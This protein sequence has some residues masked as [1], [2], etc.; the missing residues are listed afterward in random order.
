MQ[1]AVQL[2][3][4]NARVRPSR[5]RAVLH[6]LLW[7]VLGA[8]AVYAIGALP[9]PRSWRL[10][11][12]TALT[13]TSVNVGLAVLIRQQYVVNA[14]FRL[15]TRAPRRWPLRWRLGLAEV[16][17]YGGVHVGAAVAA[18][19]WFLFFATETVVH[20][21]HYS[22]PV[23]V[24]T[25]A[26]AV[27]LIVIV[28]GSSP[29]VRRRHH[30]LFE[31]VHR[32][33]GWAALGLFA[34]LTVLLA[35][36]DPRGL[37]TGLAHTPTAW[38]LAG[39]AVSIVI[40]WLQLRRLAV[41]AYVPSS[42]AAVLH[43]PD[44]RRA[45]AGTFVRLAHQRLGQSH[46]FAAIPDP[47]G[48]GYR[49]IVSRAGDWT[50]KLIDSP[51]DRVWVRGVPID[52]VASVARLFHRVVWLAT[53]SG[54]APC[55]PHLL[56]GDATRSHLVWVTRNPQRTYGQLLDEI[57]AAAPDAQIWDTDAHGKPDLAVLATYAYQRTG[58]EA[59]ICISNQDTTNR[60]VAQLRRRGVPAYGPIWDS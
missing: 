46:A 59:V 21:G 23:R 12:D 4:I 9:S 37:A 50:G 14:L 3:T 30:D 51:P 35:A 32:Y 33:G 28:A 25:G 40:P 34:A 57:R 29:T 31:A 22:T 45:R 41:T 8:N 7:L 56:A 17:Q 20:P 5:P 36:E 54:I 43:L 42:H 16:Y 53:G 6:T 15:A 19:V 44:R 47:D 2:T 11:A 58:A 39:A 48:A 38:I 24:V 60:L 26:I 49:V 18:T 1:L 52:G 13:A 55:L 27:D 10:L